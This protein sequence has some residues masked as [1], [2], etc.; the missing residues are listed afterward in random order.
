MN[1]HLD[2]QKYYLQA[3]D[4]SRRGVVG[5]PVNREQV[6][7]MGSDL[8]G[9]AP[10]PGTYRLMKQ[11]RDPQ[12]GDTRLMQIAINYY[13]GLGWGLSEVRRYLPFSPVGEDMRIYGRYLKMLL[14]KGRGD[15]RLSRER[16]HGISA[17]QVHDLDASPPGVILRITAAGHPICLRYADRRESIGTALHLDA[18][19]MDIALFMVEEIFGDWVGRRGIPLH[20]PQVTRAPMASRQE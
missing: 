1:I 13:P 20:T 15:L 11:F 2:Q 6:L 17:L 5:L 19:D 3:P 7:A 18:P 8:A 14:G 10:I 12:Y 9:S 4:G 16:R